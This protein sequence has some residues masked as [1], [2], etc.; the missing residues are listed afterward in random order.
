MNRHSVLIAASLWFAF[1]IQAQAASCDSLR[2]LKL[3]D[4]TVTSAAEVAAGGFAPADEKWSAPL[5]KSLPA[6][7]RVTATLKP[8]TDSD[9]R[10]EV[11]MPLTGWNKRL[12]A[13]G[14]GGFAGRIYH[15]IL[16]EAI[17]RGSAAVETDA[18]H[19]ADDTDGR[20]ALGH[21]EKIADWGWRA[22]HEMA[23]KA[24]AIVRAFYNS[25]PERSY[26]SGCSAGGRQGL[27]EAQRFPADYDGILSGAPAN[28]WSALMASFGWEMQATEGDAYI[29]A[30]K[31]PAISAAVLKA[32][33][34]ADDIRDGI[35][36]D[37]RACH[38]DPEV[39]LCKQGDA[40]DCLTAPQIGALK[41]IYAGPRTS[42]GKLIYP[43]LSLVERPAKTAG[44]MLPA[45]R[46]T[47]ECRPFFS[48]ASWPT[49]C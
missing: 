36:N 43:G 44:L 8:S 12:E 27:M 6:F 17:L 46:R 18:G 47:K 1:A 30:A 31:L 32:C 29:P 13:L 41:K 16:G 5:F 24:K 2:T 33:D 48:P 45:W 40:A 9:I 15:G 26:F 22:I 3:S 10:I 28:D 4:T 11:W 7:C 20:W 38:F 14:N 34:S 49:W 23:A 19:E 25:G 39:M 42:K 21:P 37:P 35:I